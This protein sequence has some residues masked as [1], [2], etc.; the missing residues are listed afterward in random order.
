MTSPPPLGYQSPQHQAN[1][2]FLAK[3]G[4]RL[5]I[6]WF[7]LI[8]AGLA[9]L[10]IM[11]LLIGG[12][13]VKVASEV[14]KL[15]REQKQKSA[16]VF[17]TSEAEMD[18]E[19]RNIEMRLENPSRPQTKQ[20]PTVI[21]L[22]AIERPVSQGLDSVARGIAQWDMDNVDRAM[23][24]GERKRDQRARQQYKGFPGHYDS[25]KR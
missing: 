3:W 18:R 22:R 2:A 5:L 17:A 25:D 16:G 4:K 1:S 6:I 13:A 11:F 19:R 9:V 14:R 10:A 12:C 23:R 15:E 21:D 7:C 8:G 20:E 24:E